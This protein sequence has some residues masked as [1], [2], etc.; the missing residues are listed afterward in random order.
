MLQDMREQP[1]NSRRQGY[2]I[3]RRLS[4]VSALVL[5]AVVFVW[6]LL[7]SPVAPAPA[8]RTSDASGPL[9]GAPV[10]KF[11]VVEHGILYRSGQP[12]TLLLP[13][14]RHFGIMSVVNLREAQ[15]DD[16]K[17]LLARLGFKGYLHLPIDNH[18]QPTEAQAA[19]FL[20]FVQDKRHW[21][22]L[23]HCAEG[24]G[25]TGTL[26]AL[27]RYAVDGWPMDRALAEADA[28]AVGLALSG[29]QREWLSQ[30][31]ASHAPGDRRPH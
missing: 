19:A 8:W 7:P 12:H 31:A 5:A 10:R 6:N 1:G 29:P 13:W 4:I 30:W 16:G 28:Y 22:V 23:V 26:I 2:R 20:E 18:K 15:S 21:P 25:R 14:L 27:T 24:E 17:R 11:G 9:T 3:L